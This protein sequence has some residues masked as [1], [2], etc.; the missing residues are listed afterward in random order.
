MLRTLCKNSDFRLFNQQ[1]KK[2]DN[3]KFNRW[4]VYDSNGVSDHRTPFDSVSFSLQIRLSEK[5][6]SSDGNFTALLLDFSLS[7]KTFDRKKGQTDIKEL[8]TIFAPA[9]KCCEFT[10]YAKLADERIEI[11][12]SNKLHI[13]QD[14]RPNSN[15]KI[16]L[17]QN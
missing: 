10:L 5:D 11:I 6:L 4:K 12:F 2:Y 17:L 1:I 16:Q 7:V 9:G 13:P 15:T 8:L 14:P 3:P